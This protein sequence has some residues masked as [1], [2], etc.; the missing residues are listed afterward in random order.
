[1]SSDECDDKEDSPV[2][3]PT[4]GDVSNGTFSRFEGAT[5]WLAL[6]EILL[7]GPQLAAIASQFL[8]KSVAGTQTSPTLLSEGIAYARAA[9]RKLL[10]GDLWYE[11]NLRNLVLALRSRFGTTKDIRDLD[12]MMQISK[13]AAGLSDLPQPRYDQALLWILWV[14]AE[15]FKLTGVW[16]DLE[17]GIAAAEVELPSLDP[18]SPFHCEYRELTAQMYDKK[19]EHTKDVTDLEKAVLHPKQGLTL[20]SQMHATASSSARAK[21]EEH[22]SQH[23][24]RLLAYT[25]FLESPSEVEKHID[26]V[27]PLLTVVHNEPEPGTSR[28]TASLACARLHC[29]LWCR[30]YSLSG[31]PSHLLNALR[32]YQFMA[33]ITIAAR[34]GLGDT[35]DSAK[36]LQFFSKAIQRVAL[37]V[38]TP[39]DD[40]IASQVSRALHAG[41]CSATAGEKGRERLSGGLIHV[42]VLQQ[43]GVRVQITDPNSAELL[44][45][46]TIVERFMLAKSLGAASMSI[47]FLIPAT[48]EDLDQPERLKSILSNFKAKYGRILDRLELEGIYDPE[49]IANFRK[50]CVSSFLRLKVLT[51]NQQ[52]GRET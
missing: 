28:T 17:D 3:P 50:K 16:R 41:F 10:P 48:R 4:A 33:T 9:N 36:L 43:V 39:E 34:P 24:E 46:D 1:M 2:A 8:R 14:S 30:A 25:R 38:Q 11:E 20:L 31:R 52:D 51:E 15:K 19:Y 22:L 37:L 35:P 32:R 21:L 40:P 7:T 47:A 26:A 29:E 12:K 6:D 45:E 27:H 5:R 44:P 49:E 18:C 23:L 42:S 13:R